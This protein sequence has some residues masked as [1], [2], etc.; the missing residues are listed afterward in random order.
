MMERKEKVPDEM[1]EDIWI[2]TK[3]LF[4]WTLVWSQQVSEKLV[5]NMPDIRYLFSSY[6]LCDLDIHKNDSPVIKLA[7]LGQMLAQQQA[8]QLLCNQGSLLLFI[9]DRVK[10]KFQKVCWICW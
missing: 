4:K 9:V 2:G 7:Y 8:K 1:K 10:W 6:V 5:L 3:W